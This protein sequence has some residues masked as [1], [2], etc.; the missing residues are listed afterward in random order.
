VARLCAVP[1]FCRHNR[2]VQNCPICA[3]EQAIELRPVVSSSAPGSSPTR[4]SS[5][6]SPPP[7]GGAGGGTTRQRRD[8]GG[9][10]AGVTVKRL[11]RGTEDGYRS[12]LLPGLKSSEDAERLAEELA[13]AAARLEVMESEPAG[14]WAEI[15]DPAADREERTWLA[16]LV[17]YLAPLEDERPFEAIDAARVSWASGEM[18]LLDGVA[19][20]PR[21]AYEPARG[22]ATVEAYRAWAAR[23]GSQAAAFTGEEAWTPERRFE[24]VFERLSLPGMHRDARFELLILLG[25]LSVYEL[26]PATLRL[27]G[28]DET[29]VAAKRALGIGD[30]MLLERRAA[31]LAGACGLPLAALDLGLR[32]WGTGERLRAGLGGQVGV[33]PDLLEQVREA[34]GL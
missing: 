15:A 22:G 12:G 23:A 25:N 26:Q 1:S 3:R 28:S 11:A 4:G 30:P 20:G 8:A 18:P 14:L 17:A 34:L 21:S 24:R 13:F 29:T 27:G 2:L 19:V 10:G 7:A 9:R 31:D 32:N 16:F 33:D 6:A 5:A